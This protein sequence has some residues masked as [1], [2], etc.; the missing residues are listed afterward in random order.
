MILALALPVFAHVAPQGANAN[1]VRV[2][3]Q[4]GG[5]N[6]HLGDVIHYKVTVDVT[7]SGTGTPAWETNLVTTFTDPHSSILTFPTITSLLPGEFIEFAGPTNPTTTHSAIYH[8]YKPVGTDP[9]RSD[10]ELGNA[11][12]PEP[13]TYEDVYDYP[14][15]PYTGTYSL[16]D[17]T[18]VPGDLVAFGGHHQVTSLAHTANAPGEAHVSTGSNYATS[19]DNVSSDVYSPD[20]VVTIYPSALSVNSGGTVTF[21]VT[22]NNTGDVALTSPHVVILQNG[23]QIADLLASAATESGLQ[24]D[25]LDIGEMM[26]WTGISSNPITV[27][28]TPFQANGHGYDNSDPP[29]DITY[30]VPQ[31]GGPVKY[32]LERDDVSINVTA[33]HTTAHMG[34][35]TYGVPPGGGDVTVTVSDT[36]DGDVVLHDA[37]MHLTTTPPGTTI[38]LYRRVDQTDTP[39]GGGSGFSPYWVGG[40][41]NNDGLMD[42]HETWTWNVTVHVNAET[43]FVVIG[44]GTDPLGNP[45]DFGLEPPGI[46]EERAIG[47]VMIYTVPGFSTIGIGV[48]IGGIAIIT[49]L[50]IYRRM[51]RHAL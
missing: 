10:L 6:F 21:T 30:T 15:N 39:G 38:D 37:H 25:I 5:I 42:I 13:A 12:M 31:G 46:P 40:D 4:V 16:L 33:P 22:E 9:T 14:D 23:V 27:D 34:L 32:A 48:M 35:S 47:D 18:I 3:I 7:K 17:Y 1:S 36:N 50:L 51:R 29:V 49:G 43:H 45:A 2:A 44:H 11:A 19:S 24:N 41:T 28:P 8:K 20:T 26:T